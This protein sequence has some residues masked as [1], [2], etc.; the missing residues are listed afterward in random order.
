ML[1]C[2]YVYSNAIY[3]KQKFMKFDFGPL[4]FA[5]TSERE[6][7]SQWRFPTDKL[8]LVVNVTPLDLTQLIN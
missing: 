1:D 5:G 4:K 6:P 2:E 7:S 8:G 3:S